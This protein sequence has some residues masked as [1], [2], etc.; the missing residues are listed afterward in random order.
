MNWIKKFRTKN[1]FRAMFRSNMGL[2]V[3]KDGAMTYGMDHGHLQWAPSWVKGV[4]CTLWNYIN[5]TIYG[6]DLTEVDAFKVHAF[7]GAPKCCNCC[8]PL[9]VDG[10]YPTPE[11]IEENDR[12]VYEQW[13]KEREAGLWDTL[14]LGDE[15]EK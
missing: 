1:K 12:I 2:C 7:P 8:A 13:N 3:G 15:E 5:C 11:E 4:V 10:R 6:H 9:L 14:P